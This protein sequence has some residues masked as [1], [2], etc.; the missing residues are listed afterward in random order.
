MNLGFY[1]EVVGI[2][3]A[4]VKYSLGGVHSS[5]LQAQVS[6]RIGMERVEMDNACLVIRALREI[7]WL[8]KSG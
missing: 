8:D 1:V 7:D 2:S 3:N 5:R 6:R 4:A